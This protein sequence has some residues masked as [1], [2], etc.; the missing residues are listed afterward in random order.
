M[1]VFYLRRAKFVISAHS[2]FY[3]VQLKKEKKRIVA[4]DFVSSSHLS[5]LLLDVRRALRDMY[6][7]I[8]VH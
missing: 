7:F 3:V 6:D 8:F 4:T 5:F 1:G 2:T